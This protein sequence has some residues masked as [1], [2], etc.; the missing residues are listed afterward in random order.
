MTFNYQ[1]ETNPQSVDYGQVTAVLQSAGLSQSGSQEHEKAFKNSDITIF[2]KDGQKVIGVGRA[3]TDFVSQGAIYNVAVA[4]DY[5]GQGV[6]HVII[7]RLLERLQGINVILYTHPQT[8]KL[9]E[10]YGFRRNKTAFAHFEHSSPE[11]RQWMEDEGFFLPEGY[12]FESEVG[13]Y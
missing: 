9:Y 6:G 10:K 8:L 11:G 3:L 12:R 5:Q 13:R 4:P 2:I 1:I 7:T